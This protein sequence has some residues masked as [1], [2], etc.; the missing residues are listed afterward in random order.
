MLDPN[1]VSL[2]RAFNAKRV[3]ERGADELIGI[4]KGVI[5]DGI[6]ADTEARFLI[7]WMD[8]NSRVACEWPFNVLYARLSDA[9][10]DG[11]LDLAEQR[12]LLDLLR[13]LTGGRMDEGF[14]QNKSTQLPLDSPPPNIIFQNR[15]FC[16]TGRLSFGTRSECCGL[17][18]RLGGN[19]L[20]TIR[21]DLNYL[22]IGIYGSN[23]WI[24]STH[25]RKI[26]K[27]VE[28]RTMGC[29]LAIISEEHWFS[30]VGAQMNPNNS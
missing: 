4:A 27:A 11:H 3:A 7:D 24:H 14:P 9:I 19:V 5:A 22:V 10:T 17:T 8:A 6:I 13:D 20:D 30:H 1:E 16:F 18:N 26:E 23:D 25:G 28:Y 2:F 15:N 21:K 12:D 29:D